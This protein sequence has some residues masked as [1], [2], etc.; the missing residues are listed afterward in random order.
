MSYN[1]SKKTR[2]LSYSTEATVEDAEVVLYT[3]PTNARA[4]M[5]LLFISNS[6][7]NTTV[8]VEWNRE[9]G[10]QHVHILGGKNMTVGE[11]VQFSDAVIVFEPGDTMV[12]TASNNASPHIDAVCTVE[13]VFIPVG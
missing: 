9:G 1:L 12:V 6:G 8:D 5:S 2:V 11:Y 3:C 7:G 4:M 10:T 13:E